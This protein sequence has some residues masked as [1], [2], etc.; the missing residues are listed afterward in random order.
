MITYIFPLL[1]MS[2]CFRLFR[3]DRRGGSN[4]EKR[5]RATPEYIILTSGVIQT[6]CSCETGFRLI[7]FAV[8]SR[9]DAHINL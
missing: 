7:Q 6:N 1:C 3:A 8:T 2:E 4:V 5:I 9:I